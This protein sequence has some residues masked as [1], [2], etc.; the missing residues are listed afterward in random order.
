[1]SAFFVGTDK[2]GIQAQDTDRRGRKQITGDR[3]P[4]LNDCQR[5]KFKAPFK[6][7]FD[8]ALLSVILNV[9]EGSAKPTVK[10]CKRFYA[11]AL[12]SLHAYFYP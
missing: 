12:G 6:D 9:A 10:D 3:S 4:F 11:I 1:M 5:L 8:R 7:Q 2:R